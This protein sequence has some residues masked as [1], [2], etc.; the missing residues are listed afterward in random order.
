MKYKHRIDFI[1]NFGGF[2]VAVKITAASLRSKQKI[3]LSDF[4]S[5]FLDEKKF[6]SAIVVNK[7][8]PKIKTIFNR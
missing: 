7:K 2:A 6:S 3:A 1:I 4:P 5:V 8:K